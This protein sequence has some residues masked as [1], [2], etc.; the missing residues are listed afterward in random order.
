MHT[1]TQQR[2]STFSA[3][4]SP[5]GQGLGH[6]LTLKLGLKHLQL[7]MLALLG[8]CWVPV[9]NSQ[10]SSNNFLLYTIAGSTG[11][12]LG[13]AKEMRNGL[14]L[15]AEVTELSK[16]LQT[17]QDGID[18]KGKIQLASSA[19][20]ADWHPFDSSFHLSTGLNIKPTNVTLGASPNNG[21]ITLNGQSYPLS[22][23]Q[24]LNANVSFPSFM[25]YLGLGWGFERVA[26]ASGFG[27]NTDLGF[28]FG[29]MNANLSTSPE[30]NALPGFKDNL[31]AQ[32]QKLNASVSNL[33]FFPV[34]KLQLGYAY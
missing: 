27:F 30:L 6:A 16:A 17:S 19:L 8:L 33:R 1:P 14:I 12:G 23:S 29:K 2:Q 32:S 10:T 4:N 15:R 13:V 3:T 9:A 11:L 20:Y 22:S 34:V 28:D 24:G 21:R 5:S 31:S 7:L 26:S 25:P 18:Y